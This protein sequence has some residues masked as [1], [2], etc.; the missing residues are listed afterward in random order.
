MAKGIWFFVPRPIGLTN[1]DSS[2]SE[3][4]ALWKG[5]ISKKIM[6]GTCVQN[7]GGNK[8]M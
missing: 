7:F 4:F 8:R 6:L 3:I 5:T 2:C 1:F